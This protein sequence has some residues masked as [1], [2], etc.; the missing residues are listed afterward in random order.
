MIIIKMTVDDNNNNN[1][2]SF[3]KICA[4]RLIRNSVTMSLQ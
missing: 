2:N 4:K 3:Y 1:K